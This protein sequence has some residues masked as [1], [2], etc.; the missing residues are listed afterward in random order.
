MRGLVDEC[1]QVGVVE[2]FND[3]AVVGE[4]QGALGALLLLLLQAI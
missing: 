3:V 4:V 2:Q 1:A